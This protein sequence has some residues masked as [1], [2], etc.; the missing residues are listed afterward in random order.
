MNKK[1]R[2]KDISLIFIIIFLSFAIRF[3][4]ILLTCFWPDELASFQRAHL[5]IPQL[6]KEL[7]GNQPLYEVFLHFW[8]KLGNS[9][10]FVRIPSLIFGVLGVY[11]LY[12][13]A[14]SLEKDKT[15]F[16]AG[17]LLAFSPLHILFSR[18]NRVYSL[19]TLLVI[20]S[21]LYL[22]KWWKKKERNSLPFIVFT[23]LYLYAHFSAYLSFIA[24]F[25]W[26]IGVG[27][28][29][30]REK[31]DWSNLFLAFFSVLVLNLPWLIYI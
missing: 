2:K 4:P 5:S 11:F 18:I 3:P 28:R 23:T 22:W 10:L 16:T 27:I 12:Q 15:S 14:K 20:L 31:K 1:E 17:L 13:L 21:W 7:R 6:L 19:L 8:I 30:K 25:V 24:Q 26:C 9:D 29:E